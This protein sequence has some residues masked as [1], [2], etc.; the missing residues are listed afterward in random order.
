[1]NL[2]DLFGPSRLDERQNGDDLTVGQ[3]ILVHRHSRFV[4]VTNKRLETILR[5]LETDTYRCGA[6]Y[7]RSHH[8]VEQAG[9]RLDLVCANQAGLQDSGHDSWRN[10]HHKELNRVARS[11]PLDSPKQ[12]MCL[13]F[14]GAP[15]HSQR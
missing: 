2:N 11:S 7:G 15:L 13:F 1:M 10:A 5:H 9:N 14:H 8:A 6:K 3:N 12:L 4:S